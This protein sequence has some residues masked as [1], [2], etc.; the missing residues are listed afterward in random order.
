MHRQ[1]EAQL[2]WCAA[3]AAGREAALERLH[4]DELGRGFE[5]EFGQQRLQG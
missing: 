5:T 3:A 4:F 1:A 2:D